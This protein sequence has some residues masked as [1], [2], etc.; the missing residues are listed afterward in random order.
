MDVCVSH[1]THPYLAGH[2]IKGV[3]VVPA[4]LVLDWFC[5]AARALRPDLTVKACHDL[6]VK[7]G[8]TLP[9][10]DAAGHRFRIGCAAQPA[11]ENRLDVD[12]SELEGRLHYTAHVEMSEAPFTPPPFVPSVTAPNRWGMSVQE[13]YDGPL[14]HGPEF[15]ALVDLHSIDENGASATLI[16]VRELGWTDEHWSADVAMLDGGL[17]LARLWGMQQL[18]S[19]LLPTRIGRYCGASPDPAADGPYLCH[20]RGRT[21]GEMRTVSNLVFVGPTGRVVATLDDLEMHAL[22]ENAHGLAIEPDELA[23]SNGALPERRALVAS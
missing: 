10:F 9:E 21:V 17:Q 16:G 6:R 14:F 4:V 1:Q 2:R 23:R 15:Q 18:G 3:A 22:P 12:L 7:R 5:R 20:L 19:P 8:I 13:A 11:S